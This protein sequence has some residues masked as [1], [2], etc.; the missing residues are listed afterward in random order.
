MALE[1]QFTIESLYWSLIGPYPANACPSPRAF[2][3][4]RVSSQEK[5]GP[6]RVHSHEVSQR[7]ERQSQGRE[8][9]DCHKRRSD[10]GQ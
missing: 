1:A 4:L 3:V 2:G 10:T 9:G 8:N 5:G 7:E 6:G